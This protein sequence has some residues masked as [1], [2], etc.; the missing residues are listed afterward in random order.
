MVNTLHSTQSL[1][2]SYLK[3][4]KKRASLKAGELLGG[5]CSNQNKLLGS[6]QKWKQWRLN[7]LPSE[8]SECII[9]GS[10]LPIR[11]RM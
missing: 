6:E 2:T 5:C 7:V 4:E 9:R 1:V 3:L 8:L 10:C 11:K